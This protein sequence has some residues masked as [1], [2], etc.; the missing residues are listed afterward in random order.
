MSSSIISSKTTKDPSWHQ[1][2]I[3]VL[4]IHDLVLAHVI[5]NSTS[6]CVECW[7]RMLAECKEVNYQNFKSR[8]S[9]RRSKI[10]CPFILW[11][12]PQMMPTWT[13]SSNACASDIVDTTVGF[14]LTADCSVTSGDLPSPTRSLN[15]MVLSSFSGYRWFLGC[16]AGT[17]DYL[18]ID[19]CTSAVFQ[20]YWSKQYQ[21]AWCI[22]CPIKIVVSDVIQLIESA[23]PC[24]NSIRGVACLPAKHTS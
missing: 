21:N 17:C 13:V 20:P 22:K 9:G 6:E 14:I 5:A 19:P 2:W 16:C 1:G 23:L 8:A 15:R 10:K 18:A 3:D 24:V 12:M 4:Q 11:E 7:F